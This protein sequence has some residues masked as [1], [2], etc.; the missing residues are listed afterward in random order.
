MVFLAVGLFFYNR[1]P[2]QSIVFFEDFTNASVW[3]TA[4][5]VSSV[6]TTNTSYGTVEYLNLSVYNTSKTYSNVTVNGYV[7]FRVGSTTIGTTNSY[8]KMPPCTFINGGTVEVT[9]GAGSTGKKLRLQEYISGAWTNSTYEEVSTVRSSIWYTQKWL[10]SG[11]GMKTFRLV[12]T[13][14]A[15]IYVG[16]I[17]ATSNQPILT[18]GTN[19]LVFDSVK[20]GVDSQIKLVSVGGSNLTGNIVVD[21]SAP[22]KV[23]NSIG[24]NYASS[25][26]LSNAGGDVYV[27]F[28][29]SLVGQYLSTMVVSSTDASSKLIN[30]SASAFQYRSGKTIKKFTLD[31]YSGIIDTVNKAIAIEVPYFTQFPLTVT[32]TVVLSQDAKLVNAGMYVF[33]DGEPQQIE[34][35]AEDGSVAS[36]TVVV[37][38]ESVTKVCLLTN[39]I[40]GGKR[41]IIGDNSITVNLPSNIALTSLKA[42]Y[43]CFGNGKLLQTDNVAKDFTLPQ[44]YTVVAE[45]NVTM[46]TYSVK[47]NLV[48]SLYSGS[49][50]YL[51]NLSSTYEDPAWITGGGEPKQAPYQPNCLDEGACK[52][53]SGVY[54]LSEVVDGQNQMRLQV[55]KCGVFTVGVTAEGQRK[56]VLSSNKTGLT[57]TISFNGNECAYGSLTVNVDSPTNLYVTAIEGNGATSVFSFEITDYVSTAIGETTKD[58]IRVYT[59]GEYV[60]IDAGKK[61]NFGLYDVQGVL[62]TR[63]RTNIS[64]EVIPVAS[65]LYFVNLEGKTYKLFVVK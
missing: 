32:P 2:A 61:M 18:V 8:I 13:A 58:N 14:S 31:S 48:D 28:E 59:Q 64:P 6:K 1:L 63:G 36:Y 52:S 38:R 41:A 12:Q 21:V 4:S 27:K 26:I 5:G 44:T 49:Y 62:L 29:P 53:D 55:S 10:I 43:S 60:I 46:K 15:S 25:A 22:F 11:S 39:F 23:S 34:V 33:N 24:G 20:A 37:S 16:D 56:V 51:S 35:Q 65:G 19:S 9:Y 54:R 7:D 30:L 42:L 3:P 40:L 17:K 45:D 47:I 50:P 57:D